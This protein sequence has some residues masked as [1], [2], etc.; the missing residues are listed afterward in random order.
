MIQPEH[1]PPPRTNAT[2][3]NISHTLSKH[4]EPLRGLYHMAKQQSDRATGRG[5]PCPATRPPHGPTSTPPATVDDQPGTQARL[6]GSLLGRQRRLEVYHQSL[7][8]GVLMTRN[9]R[10]LAL[11]LRRRRPL[12]RRQGRVLLLQLPNLLR[13]GRLG[14]QLSL[15]LCLHLPKL[16]SQGR[17]LASLT[18]CSNKAPAPMGTSEASPTPR[19]TEPHTP[20]PT[21]SHDERLPS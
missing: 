14:L 15:L 12:L 4:L 7:R 6:L 5:T 11:E 2:S 8:R 20:T 17:K 9:R 13:Q 16:A 18:A 10:Q 21:H 19:R 1:S 3:Y